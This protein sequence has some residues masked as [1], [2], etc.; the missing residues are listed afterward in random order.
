MNTRSY[1]PENV[2]LALTGGRQNLEDWQAAVK[3]HLR[4]KI[5]AHA[6]FAAEL[7]HSRQPRFMNEVFPEFRGAK[8]AASVTF[9]QCGCFLG[10]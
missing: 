2:R 4:K 6:L 8:V 10:C 1:W 3:W 7:Q 9:V 5:V